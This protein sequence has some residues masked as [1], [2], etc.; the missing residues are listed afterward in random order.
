MT[1]LRRILTRNP[2]FAASIVAAALLMRV[3]IPTGYMAVRSAEGITIELCSGVIAPMTSKAVTAMPAMHH[4]SDK[5]NGHATPE[6]PCAFAALA[7]PTLAAADPLVLALAIAFVFAA[8]F[9]PAEICPPAGLSFLRP[10]LR[11]PPVIA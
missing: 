3:L 1:A 11:G 2:W 6:S 8:I 4:G 9:R 10:P 5:R 7:A